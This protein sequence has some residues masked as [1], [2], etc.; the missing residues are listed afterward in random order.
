MAS[1]IPHRLVLEEEKLPLPCI[2]QRRKFDSSEGTVTGGTTAKMFIPSGRNQFLNCKN[3]WLNF[4]FT[5]NLTGTNLPTA[6]DNTTNLLI[7]PMGVSQCIKKLTVKNNNVTIYELDHYAKAVA[8]L[9]VANSTTTTQ[10]VRNLTNSMAASSSIDKQYNT[11]S[12]LS[13]ETK[14]PFVYGADNTSVQTPLISCSIPLLGLM[15]NTNMPLTEIEHGIQIDIE[16][17]RDVNQVFYCGNRVIADTS[18]LTGGTLN[19]SEINYE[20]AITTLDDSTMKEVEK[21][22]GFKRGAVLW[23]DN[24]HILHN[25]TFSAAQLGVEQD[26]SLIVPSL[27]YTSLNAIYHAAFQMASPSEKALY[28]LGVPHI[29]VDK[30]RYNIGGI[31]YPRNYVDSKSKMLQNTQVCNTNVDISNAVGLMSNENTTLNYRPPVDTYPAAALTTT[32]RGVVGI[33]FETFP[34]IDSIAG[35][36]STYVDCEAQI[37]LKGVSANAQNLDFW[38]LGVM[39]VVYILE[40]GE[41]RRSFN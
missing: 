10:N 11:L 4:S 38:W 5:A 31:L 28:P 19:F 33:N 27:R 2:F 15:G 26:I 12:G 34:D 40:D 37:G 1:V 20:G 3:S 32:D 7:D 25:K 23:S 22:N 8:M 14:G 39:D 17:E 16:F 29:A 35:L 9:T 6:A 41:I 21:D 18:T 13:V 36:D 24:Y 30:I